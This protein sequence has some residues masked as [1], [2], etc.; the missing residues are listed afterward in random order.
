MP[1]KA[2]EDV[3]LK[4][5]RK[6]C[7]KSVKED[8]LIGVLKNNNKIRKA[9]ESLKQLINKKKKDIEI[10]ENAVNDLYIAKFK[11]EIDSERYKVLYNKLNDEYNA[12]LNEL[13]KLESEYNSLVSNESIDNKKDYKKIVKEYLQLKKPTRELLANL[14]DK[15]LIDENRNI[16]IYYKIRG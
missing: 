10:N 2:L 15:I 14:V 3:V 6:D 9:K 12:L 13:K 1:Y 4:Q 5:I 8:S 7:K 16:E 11:K